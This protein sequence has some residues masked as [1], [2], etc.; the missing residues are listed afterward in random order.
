MTYGETIMS[1]LPQ[2]V[3]VPVEAIMRDARIGDVITIEVRVVEHECRIPNCGT[4]DYAVSTRKERRVNE[5]KG[6]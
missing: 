1:T 6:A 2:Q 4:P 3:K 5:E